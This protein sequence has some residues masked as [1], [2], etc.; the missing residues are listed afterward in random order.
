MRLGVS[1]S[2]CAVSLATVFISA[3]LWITVV[4]LATKQDISTPLYYRR[5]Y[6]VDPAKLGLDKVSSLYGPG[7]WAAWLFTVVACCVEQLWAKKDGRQRW[8]YFRGININ[9]IIAYG[10]PITATVDFFMHWSEYGAANPRGESAP[11][12]GPYAARLSVIRGGSALCLG[13]TLIYAWMSTWTA[14]LLGS[15]ISLYLW[16]AW[17][18]IDLLT[19]WPGPLGC[20]STFLLLPPF[21]GRFQV[22][23]KLSGLVFYGQEEYL[24]GTWGDVEQTQTIY[25]Y[26]SYYSFACVFL[27][28]IWYTWNERA[29]GLIYYM[30]FATFGWWMVQVVANFTS[31]MLLMVWKTKITLPVSAASIYDIDEMVALI[32]SGVFVLLGVVIT[33]LRDN[34]KNITTG[35]ATARSL[36]SSGVQSVWHGTKLDAPFAWLRRERDVTRRSRRTNISTN[37]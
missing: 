23:P 32:L 3:V 2:T 35:A 34:W 33:V 14:T 37:F 20:L 16:V 18:V 9:F 11:W 6:I 12:Q 30:G 27:S 5:T 19:H 36:L 31:T 4:S 7:F 15:V 13:L 29:F 8:F 17:A 22:M 24:L 10:Y 1:L 25:R 26:L 28:S 21:G